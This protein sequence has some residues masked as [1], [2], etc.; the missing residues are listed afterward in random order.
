M[1]TS[2]SIL[3]SI[4]L[5]KKYKI[6]KNCKPGKWIIRI[7]RLTHYQKQVLYEN[8]SFIF[9]FMPIIHCIFLKRFEISTI[10]G[11]NKLAFH[12]SP[13]SQ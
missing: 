7:N 2:T 13:F 1:D 5:Y 6:T 11:A 9:K 8:S 12:C 4:E 10:N 3:L